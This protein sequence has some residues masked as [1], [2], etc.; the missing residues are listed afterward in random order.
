MNHSPDPLMLSHVRQYLSLNCRGH[1]AA[2]TK[3]VIASEIALILLARHD[4]RRSTTR[5]VELAVHALREAGEPVGSSG[6]G[7]FWMICQADAM[8]TA[9]HIAPR[10]QSMRVS[11]D[12]AVAWAER[13]PEQVGEPVPAET[14]SLFNG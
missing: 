5:M 3:D 11:F 13:L 1:G 6:A 8:I 14:G 4:S 12:N 2:Q 10:F 7:Y 9:A